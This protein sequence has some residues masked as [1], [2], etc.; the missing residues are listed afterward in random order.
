MAAASRNSY[1]ERSLHNAA[2]IAYNLNNFTKA[3][4]L[5]SQLVEVA[6]SDNNRLSGRVGYLR[7][8]VHLAQRDS[9]VSAARQLLSEP[10]ITDE[11][12]DEARISMARSY[13]ETPTTY[14]QADSLYALLASSTNGDY[15]GEASYRKAEIR[16]LQADYDAAERVI[17]SITAAP[18]SDYW[19]AKSFIL[20]AD[21][22][23]ARGNNLQAKQTLQSIIDNYDGDDLV[24][25]ALQKRNAILE[26]EKPVQ[27]PEEEE[28]VIE[29]EKETENQ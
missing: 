26:E 23:H 14:P 5:Y 28:I 27:Q 22:F 13:Y 7:S 8:W 19:L 12:R 15:S 24:Q 4:D 11:L 2:N 9:I 3:L 20:W 21:I 10:K 6:E 18:V 29:L 25:L 1:T 16:F 17:E